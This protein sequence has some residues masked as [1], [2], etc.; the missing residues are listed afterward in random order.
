VQQPTI[1]K[2]EEDLLVNFNQDKGLVIDIRNQ[3]T[4]SN[5]RLKNSINL[6]LMSENFVESFSEIKKDKP[7]LI[8]CEDGT[9]SRIAIRLLIEMGFTKLY[10]LEQGIAKWDIKVY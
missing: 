1:I 10:T 5:N 2:S 3:Q 8:Y 7:I 6:D 9:R 4:S